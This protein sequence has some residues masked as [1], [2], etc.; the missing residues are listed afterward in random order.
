V[1]ISAATE[2]KPR[3]EIEMG[4]PERAAQMIASLL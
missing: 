1:V 4:G 3:I 2:A